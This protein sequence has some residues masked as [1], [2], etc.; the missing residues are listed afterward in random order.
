MALCDR[1]PRLTVVAV[2]VIA[3]AAASSGGP[4]AAGLAAM[5]SGLVVRGLIRRRRE[6]VDE[7]DLATGLDAVAGLAA[8]LRAGAAPPPVLRSALAVLQRSSDAASAVC[9]A[10]QVSEHTGAPLADVLDRVEAQLRT[11]N[12]I[13][14]TAMAHTA[15]ARATALLLAALPIGGIGLGYV[16]GVDPLHLLL[17]TPLGALCAALAAAFQLAGLAWSRRLSKVDEQ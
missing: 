14:R 5:Y 17:R 10:W 1:R 13:R 6:R 12:R 7:G 3:A 9:A 11:Q 2:A 8:D 4:V 15:G 16:L